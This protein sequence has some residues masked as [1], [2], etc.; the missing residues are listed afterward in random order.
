MQT[1]ECTLGSFSLYGK[2]WL[3]RASKD[4]LGLGINGGTVCHIL[5]VPYRSDHIRTYRIF[6]C[7]TS[8]CLWMHWVLAFLCQLNPLTGPQL[9]ERGRFYTYFTLFR[10]L[11][12][13][14]VIV[15][16]SKIISLH[17]KAMLKLFFTAGNLTVFERTVNKYLLIT[18]SFTIL[19]L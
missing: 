3:A 1:L 12:G 17:R 8:V 18:K 7:A 2:F 9:K 4:I 14:W 11:S 19:W 13:L 6:S 5:Y 16:D 10:P 15:Y